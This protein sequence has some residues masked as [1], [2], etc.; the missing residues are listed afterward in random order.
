MTYLRC[1]GI[2]KYEFVA[3]LPGLPSK[4]FRN[5]RG[6]YMQEFNVLFF[7]SRCNHTRSDELVSSIESQ[8]VL[9][10]TYCL[11]FTLF[12]CATLTPFLAKNFLIFSSPTSCGKP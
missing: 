4:E 9:T 1:G 8:S 3:N 12:T 5:T 11:P 6:S 7:E 2:C 10:G